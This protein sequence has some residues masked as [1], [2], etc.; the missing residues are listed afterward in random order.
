MGSVFL[1]RDNMLSSV[2]HLHPVLFRFF[3]WSIYFF[4][5]FT[6]LYMYA[7]KSHHI[8]GQQSILEHILNS[9]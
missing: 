1:P 9:S 7:D 6:K 4:A 2:F 3:M 8:V 5:T